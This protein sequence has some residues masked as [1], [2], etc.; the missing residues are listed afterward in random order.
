MSRNKKGANSLHFVLTPR[1]DNSATPGRELLSR[2]SMRTRTPGAVVETLAATDA[3]LSSVRVLDAVERNEATLVE[4]S[5]EEAESLARRYPD[6]NVAP[7]GRL[8]MLRTRPFSARL[9]RARIP[10][11]DRKMITVD[12]MDTLTGKPIADVELVIVFDRRT[13]RGITGIRT[14]RHGRANVPVP[15]K[16][17]RI[18]LVMANPDDSYWPVAVEGVTLPQATGITLSAVPI[19]PG[20]EDGLRRCCAAGDASAGEG[21]KVALIDAG[22]TPV[23]GMNIANGWNMTGSEPQSQ[24]QDNGSG[25]GTH[26]AGIIAYLAPAAELFVYRVFEQGADSAGE[27]AVA[28]AIRHAV[29][30][31]C[32][33]INLSLGQDTEP[34]AIVRETRRARAFG[35][36]CLAAAGNDHGDAVDYPARSPHMV[37]VSACGR[38]DGWP[39]GTPVHLEVAAHPPGITPI[40][41]A[42]FSNCGQEIDL[43]APGSGVIST[44]SDTRL[45]VMSGTSMAC[46]AATGLLARLL[47]RS[48]SLKSA[49]RDEQRFNGIL[50]LGYG[51]VRPIG[52]GS[53]YEGQ[54]LIDA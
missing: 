26:V 4:M 23:P 48:A 5:V 1:V 31:G 38:L 21:V 52:F 40:Y 47:G 41:F 17:D 36:V 33:L 9:R 15:G 53:D 20:F 34:F 14:D 10:R 39:R 13:G 3:G 50:S 30:Q 49:D 28:K 24:W 25:H 37:A 51:N 54:G 19:A 18:D 22:V 29:D 16:L 6:L 46:P 44:V 45:G 32:D 8:R 11:L 27:L 7:E 42:A 35:T 43:I 12:L 2:L